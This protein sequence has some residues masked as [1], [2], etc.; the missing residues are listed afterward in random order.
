MGLMV[1]IN[2]QYTSLCDSKGCVPTMLGHD[3]PRT[4]SSSQKGRQ[5]CDTELHL[6]GRLCENLKFS[7]FK[8]DKRQWT[9]TRERINRS[10]N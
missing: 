7:S 5:H 4:D 9:S 6:E 1:G 3:G 10:K 8:A 2:R